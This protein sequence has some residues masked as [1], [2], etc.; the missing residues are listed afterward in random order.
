[1]S[2]ITTQDL[3]DEVRKIA[4]EMPD[5]VYATPF[6]KGCSYFG[7]QIGDPTGQCCIMGQAF[8]NL[9]VDTSEIG[10]THEGVST[11]GELIMDSLIPV[12]YLNYSQ[13]NWLNNVQRLQD[14][15]FS[16]GESVSLVDTPPPSKTYRIP[17]F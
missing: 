7:R 10:E 4:K 5:F 2:N 14:E 11:V 1:M 12:T 8:K 17:T 15:G 3:I 13:V 16:W 9:G 6:T